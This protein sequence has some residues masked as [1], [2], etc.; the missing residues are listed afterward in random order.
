NYAST[1][2]M[3]LSGTFE[4]VLGGVGEAPGMGS[5]Q[6]DARS[7]AWVQYTGTG[8]DMG[9]TRMNTSSGVAGAGWALNDHVVL[10]AAIADDSTTTT[11]APARVTGQPLGVFVYAIDHTGDWR[12]AASAG[13]G[14]LEQTSTRTLTTLG[15]VGQ[16]HS[17]GSF[18]GVAARADYHWN[19][20]NHVYLSPYLDASYLTSHYGSAQESGAGPL[21]IHYGGL[22][23]QLTRWSVGVRLGMVVEEAHSTLSPWLQVGEIGYSGDRNPIEMQSI[24]GQSFAVAGSA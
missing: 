17:T 15:L 10:G 9:S 6:G 22:S 13:G 3:A 5:E 2:S 20:V 11:L 19:W 8:G 21:D 23:Q 12:L 1:A 4:T 14:S 24:G 7:G 18:A 16:A